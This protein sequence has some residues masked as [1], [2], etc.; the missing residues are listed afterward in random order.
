MRIWG[1]SYEFRIKNIFSLFS[2]SLWHNQFFI[3]T[4]FSGNQA[5]VSLCKILLLSTSISFCSK[6]QYETG[7]KINQIYYITIHSTITF[8]WITK[9]Q[10]KKWRRWK[11][12]LLTYSHW[13]FR[14]VVIWINVFRL[15]LN[16]KKIVSSFIIKIR[17]TFYIISYLRVRANVFWIH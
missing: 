5:A 8:N 7:E 4:H 13:W 17:K 3:N 6:F 9:R 11:K 10:E 14:H 12:M 15:N 2:C 16:W 1:V